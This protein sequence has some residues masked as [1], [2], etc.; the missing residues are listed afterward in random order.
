MLLPFRDVTNRATATTTLLQVLLAPILQ[1]VLNSVQ[2]APHAV[3]MH[4]LIITST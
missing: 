1:L 4:A 2:H 3:D